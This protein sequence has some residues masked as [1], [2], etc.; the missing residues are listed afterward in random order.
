MVEK[1]AAFRG[2]WFSGRLATQAG[3]TW[4]NTKLPMLQLGRDFISGNKGEVKETF[5][6]VLMYCNELGLM[7]R[8]LCGGR[9]TAS[10]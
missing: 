7:R 5:A 1:A 3:G 2:G 4:R 8:I 6:Q 10:L 9:A